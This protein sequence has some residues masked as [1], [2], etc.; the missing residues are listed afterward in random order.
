[1]AGLGTQDQDEVCDDLTNDKVVVQE[2]TIEQFRQK[3]VDVLFREI[4]KET[5]NSILFV[6]NADYLNAKLNEA[7]IKGLHKA[8]SIILEAS[9]IDVKG[10]E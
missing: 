3:L 7:I 5:D 9:T 8:L 1:M 10:G 6:N 4:T 2:K